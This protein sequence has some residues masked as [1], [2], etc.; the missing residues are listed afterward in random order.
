[1]KHL[2]DLAPGQ[3]GTIIGF[4]GDFESVGK[5]MEMGVTEGSKICLKRY[6]PFGDPVQVGIRG[7]DLVF[8]KCDA[9]KILIG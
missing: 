5:L 7:Y 3:T 9:K 8:R 2:L 4:D 6:A 1:M